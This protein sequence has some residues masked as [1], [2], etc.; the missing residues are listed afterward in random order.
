MP[1]GMKFCL[2][3]EMIEFYTAIKEVKNTHSFLENILL[4]S[5]AFHK[6][7]NIFKQSRLNSC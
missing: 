6:I 2:T 3:I 1:I 7:A 4:S 5:I